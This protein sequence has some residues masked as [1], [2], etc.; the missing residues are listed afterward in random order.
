MVARE[1]SLKTKLIQT[2]FIVIELLKSGS[3]VNISNIKY[4][5]LKTS[6][7]W[8][9]EY[10]RY[11]PFDLENHC[12]YGL[13][14]FYRAILDCYLQS[15]DEIFCKYVLTFLFMRHDTPISP[16]TEL[17]MKFFKS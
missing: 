11:K 5:K 17:Y 4:R 14:F 16:L 6:V 7:L 13:D 12:A 15:Y 1:A 8:K 9:T 2:L 3:Q 10:R